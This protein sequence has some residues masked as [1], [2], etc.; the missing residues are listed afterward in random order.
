VKKNRDALS[1]VETLVSLLREEMMIVENVL[2]RLDPRFPG[3][4]DAHYAIERIKVK[5]SEVEQ[6]PGMFRR[7]TPTPTHFTIPVTF[8]G[9]AVPPIPVGVSVREWLSRDPESFEG[10]AR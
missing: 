6:A 8:A 7:P 5:L 10:W 3:A 9:T 2:S 4:S 1:T